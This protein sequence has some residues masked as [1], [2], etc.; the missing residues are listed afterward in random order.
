M[1]EDFDKILDRCIDRINNGDSIANCLSDYPN[2][3]KS[4]RPLLESIYGFQKA[5]SFTPSSDAKRAARQKF[6][7]ALDKTSE[8]TKKTPF[9]AIPRP[10][11]WATVAAVIMAIIGLLVIRPLINQPTMVT[12]PEDNSVPVS[13][14]D[15]S[16]PT[17]PEDNIVPSSEGNFV[18]LI[19]DE[20]N[21]IGDF[22]NL[23]V[24]ISEVGLHATGSSAG[25]L[26]F[27]P[28]TMTV[29]LTQ[30]QGEQSQE[31][32]RGDVPAGQY[33]QVFI[34]VIQVEGKLQST[35]E[36]T[37]VTL[38]SSKLHISKPFEVTND[39]LTSFTFDITVIEAGKSGRYMLKPQIS[40]SGA[41]QE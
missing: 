21:D 5:Y 41:Q 40:E 1:V 12:I 4:L 7:A 36:T 29:D 34:Y 9:S 22:V 27:V 31:I 20:P 25:W 8:S 28:E 10:V 14:E 17:T 6:Y 16:V 33:S 19:S 32:W 2:Y 23:N 39:T 18:F 38:P 3:A 13:P 24:T 26:E 30:V 15:D 37:E 11:V 35:G